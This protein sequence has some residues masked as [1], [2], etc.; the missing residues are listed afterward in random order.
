MPSSTVWL[1]SMSVARPGPV[2]GPGPSDHPI[3]PP[4][5]AGRNVSAKSFDKVMAAP[6]RPAHAGRQGFMRVELPLCR[7]SPVRVRGSVT[8]LR[9]R[10]SPGRRAL[11]S[12]ESWSQEPPCSTRPLLLATIVSQTRPTMSQLSGT[13]SLR[14]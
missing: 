1:V 10:S 3:I 14:A 7:K 8:N 11:E 4:L 2:P 9:P 13:R 6:W 12:F 5:R